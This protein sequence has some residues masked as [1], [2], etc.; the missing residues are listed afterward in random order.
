MS[1]KITYKKSLKNL[2]RLINSYKL[3]PSISVHLSLSYHHFC[4][5]GMDLNINELQNCVDN[6]SYCRVKDVDIIQLKENLEELINSDLSVEDFL[7]IK[8]NK[9]DSTELDFH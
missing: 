2:L 4:K 5:Y 6:L 9:I 3:E 7:E 8:Q 1:K